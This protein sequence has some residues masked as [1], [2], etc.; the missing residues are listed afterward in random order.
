MERQHQLKKCES[1]ALKTESGHH[2]SVT[3]RRQ[4]NLYNKYMTD[5]VHGCVTC[6]TSSII[7]KHQ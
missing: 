6:T 1:F 3:H 5:T 4:Q 7:V 2:S